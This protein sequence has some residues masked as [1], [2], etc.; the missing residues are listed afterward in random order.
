MSKRTAL[1]MTPLLLLG[2]GDSLLDES[3]GPAAGPGATTNGDGE[4]R[5]S[6]VD[7]TDREAWI[8]LSLAGGGVAVEVADPRAETT[9]DLGF[10]RSNIRLNGGASGPGEGALAPVVG[11]GFDD[12]TQAPES[13]W[14]TDEPLNPGDMTDGG[15]VRN[16]GVDFAFT[17]ANPASDNGWFLYD[18]ATHVLSPAPVVFAI[19]GA[20]GGYFAFEVIDWYDVDAGTS[21]VWT[22]RW[23]TIAAPQDPAPVVPLEP[24]FLVNAS[25]SGSFTYLRMADREVVSPEDPASSPD[26]DLGFSR[27]VIRTNSGISGPGLA[28]AREA[29]AGT[30][31]SSLSESPTSGFFVDLEL[32]IP[33]PPGSGTAPAN[34]GIRS[35]FDYDP[36]THA[37]SPKATFFLIR[38]ASGDY[39]KLRIL[40]WSEGVF[41]LETSP[42]EVAPDVFEIEVDAT[43]R[44]APTWV[45]LRLGA[46]IATSTGAPSS[47]SEWD[48]AFTRVLIQTNSG[49]SGPGSGGAMAVDG[50][51][52]LDE[53]AEAPETGYQVDTM[54]TP[55]R[56]GEPAAPANPALEDWF[57][58]DSATMTASPKP[59]V[60]AVRTADGGY[61]AFQIL[62]YDRGMYQLQGI[63]AGAGRRRFQ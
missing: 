62:S 44:E 61:A 7:A 9:W 6:V 19:R 53:V 10:R 60:Y 31:Y 52:A 36:S 5:T 25:M 18:G 58:Y 54:V 45:S 47:E 51:T 46:V 42:L 34:P 30:E 12:L 57:D 23:K 55:G 21:A 28:G 3:A 32:P 11:V 48:L 37:V 16:D 27:T 63:Y 4:V 41:R 33:G 35:W 20:L 14:I 17:R 15:P 39:H 22:F 43:S 50:V 26:W 56:P 24:G 59:R 38:D 13:G 1:L 29:P 8:Y 49:V 40:D 2:C